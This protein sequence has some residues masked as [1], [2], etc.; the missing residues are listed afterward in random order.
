MAEGGKYQSI[1]LEEFKPILQTC[2]QCYCG[3][4]VEG[5]P[6][7]RATL[8]ESHSARGLSQI[9]LAMLEGQLSPAEL[10]DSLVYSCTG[11]R[12]CEWNCS[13]NTPKYIVEHGN[14]LNKVSGA[15]VA[16][17]IRATKVEGGNVP[18]K[19]KNALDNIAKYGN[20]YGLPRAKKDKWVDGLGLRL[21]GQDTILYVGA[22]V[23]YEDRATATANALID[24]LRRGGVKFGMIG[25]DELDSGAFARPF[26]E[27]GL[28]KDMV[29]HNL[30]VFKENKIKRIICLSPHDMDTFKNYY[31]NLKSVEIKHYTQVLW[32]LI[33][34]GKIKPI[35]ELKKKVTYHDP[36][37]LGRRQGVYDEPRKILKSIPGLEFV[38]IKGWTKQRSFCCGGGGVGLFYDVPEVDIDLMRADQIKETGAD[39]VA[40]ACPICRQMIEDAMKSRGYE[41]EVKDV[42][43]LIKD[44]L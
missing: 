38:E 13:L 10:P 35:K 11:C 32:E 3:L 27:E 1:S 15:T 19:I 36:C 21:A 39:L 18:P 8:N 30:K 31:E 2:I 44:V 7:Y 33:E 16:E 24:I 40:V 41:I 37:Y 17:L 34:T 29:E 23:P 22:I 6:A 43:E 28:F 14:R 25:G 5:C 9:A 26:G 42:A 12:W 20:P 4:C